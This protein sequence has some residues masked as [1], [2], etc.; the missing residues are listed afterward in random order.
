MLLLFWGLT[1]SGV[2]YSAIVVLFVVYCIF[3]RTRTRLERSLLLLLLLQDEDNYYYRVD[4][5]T[6]QFYLYYSNYLRKSPAVL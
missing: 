1:Q 6:V 3:Y 2:P 5:F 4:V